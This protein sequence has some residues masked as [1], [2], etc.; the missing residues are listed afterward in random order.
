VFLQSY[1]ATVGGQQGSGVAV[2]A[3]LGGMVAGYLWLRGRRLHFH[4]REPLVSGYKDWKLRRAKKKFEVYLKKQDSDR[5][6]WVH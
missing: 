5:N 3:H 2:T 6:R 4:V 1:M